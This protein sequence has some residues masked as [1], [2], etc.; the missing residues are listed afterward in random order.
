[1]QT[2]H[3]EA[4]EILKKIDTPTI[5]NAIETFNVRGR[6]E[7]FLGMDIKCFFPEL[8]PTVGY[9]LTVTVDSTTPD[10]TR[11][12]EVWKKWVIEMEKSPKP[13]V[14]VFQDVGPQP[15]K[16]A[17]IGEVMATLAKRLGVIGLVTDGGVRDLAEV[18]NLGLQLFAPGCVASHGNPRLLAV[19]EPVSIDGVQICTGDLIHGD[20]NGVT[21]I[22]AVDVERLFQAVEKIQAEERDLMDYI[23]SPE[24]NI[25]GFFERKFSH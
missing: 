24:F 7:G 3:D 23:K 15:K 20:L 9:A 5:C 25:D 10:V 6:V 8:D 18:R 14:L 21:L 1:M 19:G 11:D 16:S 4:L 13:I 22:P 17:H 2:K 12:N